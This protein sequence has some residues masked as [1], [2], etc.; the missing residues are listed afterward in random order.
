MSII[1]NYKIKLIFFT[2]LLVTC[3]IIGKQ[4]LADGQYDHFLSK[5]GFSATEDVGTIMGGVIQGFLSLLSIIFIVL[6]L[7]AGFNWMTASGDEQ[8]VEKAKDTITKAVIG[9]VIIIAAFSITYFVFNALP[10]GTG[11]SGETSG[12]E[13]SGNVF[14]DW[15]SSWSFDDLFSSNENVDDYS[16]NYIPPYNEDGSCSVGYHSC[17]DS[18]CC[19]D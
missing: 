14:S 18:G 9:L 8:K 10:Y 16:D 5:T 11:S 2:L 17:G 4:A 15:W 7:Y 12:P 6:L 13:S 19:P 1:K 3:V